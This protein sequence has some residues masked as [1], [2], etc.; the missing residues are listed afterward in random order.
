V[1]QC[2]A[3][4][5]CMLQCVAVCC[6]VLQCVAVCRSVLQW[7]FRGAQHTH[8]HGSARPARQAAKHDP[9]APRDTSFGERPLE[10]QHHVYKIKYFYLLV[11]HVPLVGGG[12]PYGI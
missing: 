12:T 2:V 10:N 9:P 3:V 1:L 6:S 4:C 11:Y 5:C 7:I 8:T